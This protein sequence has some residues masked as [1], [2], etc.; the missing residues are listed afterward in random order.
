MLQSINSGLSYVLADFC[1]RFRTV[2]AGNELVAH[3]ALGE[4]EILAFLSWNRMIRPSF[5]P[6][7]G[8]FPRIS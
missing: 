5:P 3:L 7:C 2:S 4:F 6:L 8:P 1:G